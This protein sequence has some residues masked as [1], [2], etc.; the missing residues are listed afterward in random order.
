M[1]VILTAQGVAAMLR[2]SKRQVYELAK[3][4]ENPE[5]SEAECPSL[6]SG[7]P[8]RPATIAACSI[9]ANR[10]QRD[11][12]IHIAGGIVALFLVWWMLRMFVL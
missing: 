11:W 8:R 2:I 1:N 12:I 5:I 4:S 10:S 9:S 7:L 3:G 6:R